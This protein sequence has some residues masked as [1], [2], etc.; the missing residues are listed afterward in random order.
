VESLLLL[1]GSPNLP[2]AARSFAATI[3]AASELAHAYTLAQVAEG[4]AEEHRQALRQNLPE[5]EAFIENGFTY[6]AA[7]LAQARARQ[8]EK[9]RTGDARARGELTRIKARQKSLQARKDES[10]AVLCRE[11]ELIVPGEITFLAHALVVPSS[12]PEDRQRYDANVEAIAMQWVRLYEETLG[13]T[14]RD[15]ST[16]ERALSAGLEA[17]PGFDLHSR[18][19]SGEE[20]AIEVK[21]R[22]SVGDVELTE[23]EYIKACNLRQRYWLYVVYECA[24]SAPRL[25]RIQD[26]FGKLIARAKGSVI[27]GEGQIF[28]AAE[29]E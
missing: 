27:I 5:R 24:K 13:A 19:S 15:V 20:L 11:A 29:G 16:A 12:D 22:A 21:G 28:A 26:P 23:N 14:V 1:R 9:A 18:R 17:W 10:L 2:I 6:Q 8:T 3:E 4:R 7:E 25:L